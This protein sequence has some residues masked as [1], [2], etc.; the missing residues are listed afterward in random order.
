MA[1][2]YKKNIIYKKVLTFFT[3]YTPI[4]TSLKKYTIQ[5]N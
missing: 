5:G 3:V 4:N 1:L 2:T